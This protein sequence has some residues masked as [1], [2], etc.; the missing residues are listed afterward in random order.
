GGGS[1]GSGGGSGGSGGGSGASC[2]NGAKDN[3]AI[4]DPNHHLL[5][6]AA[7]ITAGAA[8][9][10][11]IKGTSAHDHT[12]SLTATHMTMLQMGMSFTVTSSMTNAHTHQVTVKCA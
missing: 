12:V 7:D 1:G 3:P 6:P 2:T 11:S 10:Y 5:V 8:K 4:N 9:S